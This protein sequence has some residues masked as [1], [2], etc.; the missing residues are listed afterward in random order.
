MAVWEA[1]R[2]RDML[3][4]HVRPEFDR[5]GNNSLPAFGFRITASLALHLP[6]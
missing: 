3:L 1:G 4:E 5:L 6:P 2:E